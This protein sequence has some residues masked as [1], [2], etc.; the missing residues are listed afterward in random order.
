MHYRTKKV[1]NMPLKLLVSLEGDKIALIF[2]KLKLLENVS[3][4]ASP[5][6]SYITDFLAHTSLDMKKCS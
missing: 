5:S 1:K 2:L 3:S 6:M 4:F